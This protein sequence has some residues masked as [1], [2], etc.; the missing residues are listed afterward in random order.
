MWLNPGGI[1]VLP[2]HCS[3]LPCRLFQ[4]RSKFYDLLINCIP[5]ELILKACYRACYCSTNSTVACCSMQ[6]NVTPSCHALLLP[7]TLIS[8][9]EFH[10]PCLAACVLHPV[11]S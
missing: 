10:P 3:A 4:I 1:L 11:S 5:P 7:V 9:V 8:M 6:L 2:S